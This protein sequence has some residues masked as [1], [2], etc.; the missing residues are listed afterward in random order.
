[1]A[2]ESYHRTARKEYT[3]DKCGFPILPGDY[4][5]WYRYTG[6]G[7]GLNNPSRFHTKPTC[8]E[9]KKRAEEKLKKENVSHG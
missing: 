6:G 7:Y 3:C 5:E 8:E 4:Y 1:M 9:T 2:Y